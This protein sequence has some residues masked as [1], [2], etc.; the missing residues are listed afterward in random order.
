MKSNFLLNPN[1][2]VIL[3]LILQLVL[4]IFFFFNCEYRNVEINRNGK[5]DNV[6]ISEKFSNES[7]THTH[8]LLW[9]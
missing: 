4:W 6:L 3:G 9:K 1:V 7:Q 5:I 8:T 2:V